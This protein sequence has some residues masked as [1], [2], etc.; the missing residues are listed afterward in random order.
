[1]WVFLR[2]L[3]EPR[4]SSGGRRDLGARLFMPTLV[5]ARHNPVIQSFY[6]RLLESGKTKMALLIAAMRKLLTLLNAMLKKNESW[7]PKTA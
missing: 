4:R 2:D 7:N 3:Y 1:M 5:A 6:Q